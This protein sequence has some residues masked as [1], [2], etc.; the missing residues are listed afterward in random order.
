MTE[1][2]PAF[3]PVIRPVGLETEFGVL[4]PGDPRASAVAMASR[5]VEAYAAVSRPDARG[6][7]GAPAGAVRWDYEDEDPL[8]DLRGGRL[9]RS[10]QPAHERPGPPRSLRRRAAPSAR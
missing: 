5:V 9:D 4:A 8:A 2:A 10:P 7:D 3:R 6:P 1:P